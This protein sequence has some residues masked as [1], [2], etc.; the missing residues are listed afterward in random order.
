[1]VSMIFFSYKN[2]KIL[3]YLIPVLIFIICTIASMYLYNGLPVR[4]RLNK[5]DFGRGL[6]LVLIGFLA[7]ISGIMWPLM[8]KFHRLEAI[9]LQETMMIVIVV[10]V[11]PAF[12]IVIFGMFLVVRGIIL[13]LSKR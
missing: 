9:G 3:S 1:M 2:V 10:V 11:L 4:E 12:T 6:N 13:A 5:I 7:I 8:F